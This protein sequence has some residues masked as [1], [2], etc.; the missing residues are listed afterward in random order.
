MIGFDHYAA[1]ILIP[2]PVRVDCLKEGIEHLVLVVLRA[3][4]IGPFVLVTV[5]PGRLEHIGIRIGDPGLQFRHAAEDLRAERTAVESVLECHDH[6]LAHALFRAVGAHQLQGTLA[7]FRSGAEHE[8][9]RI[10]DRAYADQFACRFDALLRREQ[11]GSHHGLVHNGVYRF[12]D[13]GIGMAGICD[14][15]GGREIDP[16]V[17][18]GIADLVS[19]LGMVPDHQRLAHVGIGLV[20][21]HLLDHRNAFLV[22]NRRADPAVFGLNMRYI[23]TDFVKSRVHLILLLF[24]KK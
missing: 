2:Y 5:R 11:V 21:L 17:A 9:L 23:D 3:L 6:F 19:V 7:G 14:Q 18:E 8:H 20:L 1:D 10:R 12:L 24:V 13:F 22:R 4:R 16:L 15:D